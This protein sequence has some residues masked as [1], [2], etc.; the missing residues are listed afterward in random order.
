[1]AAEARLRIFMN[2]GKM[3]VIRIRARPEFS[4]FE[5]AAEENRDET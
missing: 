3:I 1:M 4:S 2:T 5:T